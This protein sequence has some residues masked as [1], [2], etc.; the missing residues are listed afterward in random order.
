M[1]T[2]WDE[3]LEK[4]RKAENALRR[5]IR[6]V[7]P[8][9][10]AMC[11]RQHNLEVK[12][13]DIQTLVGSIEVKS[14]WSKYADVFHGERYK[15]IFVPTWGNWQLWSAEGKPVGPFKNQRETLLQTRCE[16][17]KLKRTHTCAYPQ[18]LFALVVQKGIT[19]GDRVPFQ[20]YYVFTLHG[21]VRMLN[22]C[23][24]L[25]DNFECRPA[26]EHPPNRDTSVYTQRYPQETWKAWRGGSY[27]ILRVI[28]WME[29][30]GYPYWMGHFNNPGSLKE[31][32]DWM[33][34]RTLK[35]NKRWDE[36]L[37]E[38]PF[39]NRSNAD[40]RRTARS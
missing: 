40:P 26:V 13:T 32:C 24:G 12:V 25:D 20:S 33:V 21:L 5:L 7:H 30:H 9:F 17:V 14:V 29:R 4:G 35:Q 3:N 38:L 22:E 1:A 27:N 37:Q 11:V 10:D 36:D 28:K 34:D 6:Q 16:F 18:A 39:R 8:A 15:G 19:K 23:H 31:M 2:E